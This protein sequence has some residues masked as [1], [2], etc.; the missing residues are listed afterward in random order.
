MG[1]ENSAVPQASFHQNGLLEAT[2]ISRRTAQRI[3]NEQTK[4]IA[5]LKRLL[6]A[7]LKVVTMI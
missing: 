2:G 1:D 5:K 7:F 4:P 3:R 6:E